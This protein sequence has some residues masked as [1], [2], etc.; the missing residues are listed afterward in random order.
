MSTVF[1][2]SDL[3]KYAL[4]AVL[5]VFSVLLALFLDQALTE[6]RELQ[7]VDEL[8]GHIAEEISGNLEV[9]NKWFPYHESVIAKIEAH[10]ASTELQKNLIS[11]AGIDYFVLM[12]DGVLQDFYS[13]SAWQLALQSEMISK[14]D[15]DTTQKISKGYYS[16]EYVD[17]TLQRLVDFT[18]SRDAMEKAQLVHS[19]TLLRR[20]MQELVSQEYTLQRN[21]EEALSTLNKQQVGSNK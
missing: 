13:V 17:G 15:I 16:Q 21:Y 4:E 19:L 20:L 9:V 11:D 6:R 3:A 7:A 12:E 18:F 14:L 2:K 5:I 1:S 8:V 10:L